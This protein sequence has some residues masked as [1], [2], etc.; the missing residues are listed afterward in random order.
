VLGVTLQLLLNLANAVLWVLVAV[1]LRQR[2]M[3]LRDAGSV[4]WNM[5]LVDDLDWQRRALEVTKR[6]EKKV[7][8]P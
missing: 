3:L 4:L 8:I 5:P 2:R 7:G 6:I 1:E